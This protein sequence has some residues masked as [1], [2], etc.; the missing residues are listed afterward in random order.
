MARDKVGKVRSIS[1]SDVL[2]ERIK[3]LAKESGL[4]AAQWVRNT[5][6]NK[7]ADGVS[8]DERKKTIQEMR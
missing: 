6:M 3:E 7:I 4:S 2:W 5:C 1:M 8:E